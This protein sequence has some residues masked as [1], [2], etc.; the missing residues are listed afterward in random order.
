M[1]RVTTEFEL[2]QAEL[3]WLVAFAAARDLTLHAAARH[4]IR[5]L[6]LLEETPGAWEVVNALRSKALG[7]KSVAS[8][9]ELLDEEQEQEQ[10]GRM[11]ILALLEKLGSLPELTEELRAARRGLAGVLFPKGG[12]EHDQLLHGEPSPL[13]ASATRPN[14]AEM[15]ERFFGANSAPLE[16]F[17]RLKGHAVQL[18]DLDTELDA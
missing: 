4:A 12:P 8:P 17:D 14:A 18:R 1:N 5:V 13:E 15:Y 16:S 11:S 10:A 2:N 6:N 7:V 3:Q 9:Q